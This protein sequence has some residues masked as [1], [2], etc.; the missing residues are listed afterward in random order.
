MHSAVLIIGT[1]RIIRVRRTRELISLTTK[2]ICKPPILRLLLWMLLLRTIV[3]LLL[4]NIPT[5]LIPPAH[6]TLLLLHLLHHI[7]IIVVFHPTHHGHAIVAPWRN[8][9]VGWSIVVVIAG[10]QGAVGFPL[11]E[12]FEFA[13]FANAGEKVFGIVAEKGAAVERAS[14]GVGGRFPHVVE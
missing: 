7:R 6:K 4:R 2:R 9:I 3:K 8:D 1:L 13:Q 11:D 14:F 10:G 5:I 12:G